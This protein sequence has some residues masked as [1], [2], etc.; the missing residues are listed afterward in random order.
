MIARPNYM[1]GLPGPRSGPGIDMERSGTY[2]SEATPAEFSAEI[3]IIGLK[4]YMAMTSEARS[5]ASIDMESEG[6]YMDLSPR[7]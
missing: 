1:D 4:F 2:R 6:N 3:Y 5:G 7:G